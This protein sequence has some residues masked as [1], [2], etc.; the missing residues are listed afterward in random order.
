MECSAFKCTIG[1]GSDI[2]V[3]KTC[4]LHR[5][6]HLFLGEK[7]FHSFMHLDD[8][9]VERERLMRLFPIP[10]DLLSIVY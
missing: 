4:G 7:R 9:S 1:D 8:L 2:N 10:E 3:C 6:D 5:L